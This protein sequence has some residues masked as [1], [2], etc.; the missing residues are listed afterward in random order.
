MSIKFNWTGFF[1]LTL[2]LLSPI[3]LSSNSLKGQN[4]DFCSSRDT[5]YGCAPFTIILDTCGTDGQ[6]YQFDKD[7]NSF[8]DNN[9]HT[10]LLARP[11]PY[12]V[13]VVISNKEPVTN[14]VKVIEPKTPDFEVFS[15]SNSKVILNITDTYYDQYFIDWG[16][17]SPVEEVAKGVNPSHSFTDNLSKTIT[18]RGHFQAIDD[19]V[20]LC[21][22]NSVDFIP[23][24]TIPTPQLE[25]IEVNN[26]TEIKATFAQLQENTFYQLE[27]SVNGGGFN[28][29]SIVSSA[30]SEIFLPEKD[31]INNTFCYR[32]SAFDQCEKVSITSNEICS[33]D[34]SITVENGQNRIRWGRTNSF[35]EFEDY[36]VVKNGDT[37]TQ[38]NNINF[39]VYEDTTVE[40]QEEYCYQIITRLKN[41]AA[42]ITQT[43]C[44]V[45]SKS[46]DPLP[47]VE[48]LFSTV[49]DDNILVVYEIPQGIKVKTISILRSVNGGLYEEIGNGLTPFVD[50]LVNTQEN[51]YC[52]RVALEDSCGNVTERSNTNCP[53][54]LTGEKID[55][56]N[57]L[58]WTAYEGTPDLEYTLEF[59]DEEGNIIGTSQDLDKNTLDFIDPVNLEDKILSRFYRIRVSF[60]RNT[61]FISYSNIVEIKEDIDVKLPDAFTPNGDGLNDIFKGHGFYIDTFNLKIYNRWGELLFESRNIEKG[62]DGTFNGVEAPAGAYTFI[63]S[64][65]N[66][67]E[68]ILEK[69]GMFL[70]IRQ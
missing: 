55:K 57:L 29:I 69:K 23:I 9:S 53:V 51:R 42:S 12:E 24:A 61:S 28:P 13:T 39:L 15:C 54:V 65:T 14:L 30:E 67:L 40:C 60:P 37:V 5:I 27:E 3:I 50:S 41:G 45:A 7:D 32:I 19:N 49:Q 33:N 31:I 17:G 43:K 35:S 47:E 66:T 22:E 36:L 11:D 46:G 16:D 1:K 63:V 26:D 2:F 48:N 21:G 52:Y 59:L 68:N 4:Y 70:L 44:V 10:Y 20:N 25:S 6:K 58:K 8:G 18:V 56:D 38:F 62:W 34:L 64:A